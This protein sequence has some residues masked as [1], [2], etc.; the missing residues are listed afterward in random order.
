MST[1]SNHRAPWSPED[2]AK[3]TAMSTDGTNIEAMATEFGRTP[4]AVD[5]LARWFRNKI[6]GAVRCN[7]N[8]SFPCG[9]KASR[10]DSL[11]EENS[12]NR[13]TA[14]KMWDSS[15]LSTRRASSPCSAKLVCSIGDTNQ[16]MLTSRPIGSWHR[17]STSQSVSIP[18]S[19]SQRLIAEPKAPYRNWSS[20]F[21]ISVGRLSLVEETLIRYPKLRVYL[22]HG[23]A[24]WLELIHGGALWLEETI[25]ILSVYPQG[26]VHIAV[27]NWV[28]PRE[29]FH[30]YLRALVRAGFA[31]RTMFGSDQRV[32]SD[33]IGM[34]VQGIET[35]GF[36][37]AEQKRDIFYNNAARFLRLSPAEIAQ[38]HRP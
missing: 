25:A 38:H 2:V 22:M 30:D 23:G 11:E 1:H 10:N 13:A 15:G 5:K 16:A 3:L 31:K 37:T 34:A 21:R 27:I 17:N 8:G 33:A 32:W 29:Q 12:S 36:L 7:R 35:A 20:K 6:Y 26:H 28:L 14:C 4:A 19:L 9:C 24:P 18:A